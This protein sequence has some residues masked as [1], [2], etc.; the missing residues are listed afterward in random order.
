LVGG[1]FKVFGI[2]SHLSALVLLTINSMFSTLTCIFIY[3]VAKRCFGERTAVVSAW[4]WAL[5]PLA[6]HWS[7]AWIWETAWS[8]FLLTVLFWLTLTMDERHGVRPW[9]LFGLLWGLA[10]LSNPS[11]VSFLP[12]SGLWALREYARKARPWLGGVLTASVVFLACL[13]PWQIRN[14]RTFGHWFFVRGDFG[15]NLRLGNG[16]EAKGALLL[17]LIPSRNQAEFERYASMG[18]YAYAGAQGQQAVEFIRRN[19]GRFLI[20]CVKRFI[21][22]WSGNPRSSIFNAS[23]VVNLYELITSVIC[24]WGLVRALRARAPGAWLFF[25]LL[26]LFPLVYYITFPNIR[27]REP[28]EPFMIILAVFLVTGEE[29]S[30]GREVQELESSRIGFSGACSS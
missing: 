30:H 16:P 18:E 19:P 7:A 10:A 21:Y 1:V 25:W 15:M 8:T 24:V 26:L 22:F 3:L 27:Y 5:Y 2:Y 29:A 14:Y 11:L 6:I 9:S 12:A 13:L 23:F 28:L 4:V 20:L 17:N